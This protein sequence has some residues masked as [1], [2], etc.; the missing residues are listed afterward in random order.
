MQSLLAK[1]AVR[2]VEV[3]ELLGRGWFLTGGLVQ[4]D[5]KRGRRIVMMYSGM[6]PKSEFWD[7]ALDELASFSHLETLVRV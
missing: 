4:L 7:Y 5:A 2:T 3:V 1:R 6:L